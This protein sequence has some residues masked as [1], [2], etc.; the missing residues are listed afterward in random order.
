MATL[1]DALANAAADVSSNAA[2]GGAV[3][4]ASGGG[5]EGEVSLFAVRRSSTHLVSGEWWVVSGEW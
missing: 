1:E 3:G 4:G 2:D 5:G